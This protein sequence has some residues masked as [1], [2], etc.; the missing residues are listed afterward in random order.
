MQCVKEFIKI[1]GIDRKY[2]SIEYDNVG[3]KR[4][5]TSEFFEVLQ[6]VDRADWRIY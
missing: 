5:I 3:T 2:N 4:S 6:L 1:Q